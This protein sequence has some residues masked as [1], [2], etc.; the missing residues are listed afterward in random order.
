MMFFRFEKREPKPVEYRTLADVPEGVRCACIDE[1]ISY[2]NSREVVRMRKGKESFTT[3][4]MTFGTADSCK[5]VQ[6][7][8]PL[9]TP[10]MPATLAEV[11][12]G[13]CVRLGQSDSFYFL[14]SGRVYKWV[15]D[16][17]QVFLTGVMAYGSPKV[18][19]LTDI[20]AV[21]CEIEV[22]P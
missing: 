6:I 7:L 3:D 12:D 14:F 11:E 18:E 21:P 17:G 9:P 16:S 1:V 15:Q 20:Y 19:S 22:T 13:R 5:I 8:D 10:A 4:G 2:M